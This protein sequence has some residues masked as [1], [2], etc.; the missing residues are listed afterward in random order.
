MMRFP[1][2]P[3]PPPHSLILL[4]L[5]EADHVLHGLAEPFFLMVDE[6]AVHGEV[7]VF[8]GEDLELAVG[9]VVAEAVLGEE[10]DAAIVFDEAEDDVGVGDL[11]PGLDFQASLG[12]LLLQGK[13]VVVV[14]FG[15]KEALVH[16]VLQLELV[17]LG[18]GVVPVG[19]EAESFFLIHGF[20]PVDVIEG[21][22]KEISQVQLIAVEHPLDLPGGPG[23][24]SDRLVGVGLIEGHEDIADKGIAEGVDGPQVDGVPDGGVGHLIFGLAACGD[25]GLGMGVEE[26]A[27]GRQADALA[28]PVEELGVELL[29][30]LLDLDGDGR[31][32]VA[33][34]PSRLGE[35]SPV[36]HLDE[37]L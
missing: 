18:Q 28:D 29:L 35:G 27:V 36:R 4:I 19:D 13:A 20:D 16:E 30:Q 3:S 9:H 11:Q 8:H 22:V 2:P 15:E 24:D 14:L 31:L 10:G 32:G 7:E 1:G 5:K 34:L 33:E 23:G 21:A 12:Q 26:L 37:C 6:L 17:L 25:D